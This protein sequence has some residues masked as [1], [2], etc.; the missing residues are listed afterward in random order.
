MCCHIASPPPDDAVKFERIATGTYLD[1]VLNL[2]AEDIGADAFITRHGRISRGQAREIVFR[3]APA[4]PCLP[5]TSPRQSWS[6]SQ[7]T[8][9]A[10]ASFLFRYCVAAERW[11]PTWIRPK[12]AS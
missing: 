8:F 9:W 2:L 4:L 11:L 6:S 12:L 7:S 3:L 5:G 1:H 10:V